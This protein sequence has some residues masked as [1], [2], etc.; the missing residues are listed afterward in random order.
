MLLNVYRTLPTTAAERDDRSANKGDLG[1]HESKRT[2]FVSDK[3]IN[4]QNQTSHRQHEDLGAGKAK[5]RQ[6]KLHFG[7]RHSGYQ[8]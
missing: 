8:L 7:K 5:I 1:Q 4:D 2:F 6:D 3:K